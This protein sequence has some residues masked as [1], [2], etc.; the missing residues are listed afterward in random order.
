MTSFLLANRV[1]TPTS[2]KM[3][4]DDP[5]RTNNFLVAEISGR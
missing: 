2:C 1:H 4:W 3:G 5:A